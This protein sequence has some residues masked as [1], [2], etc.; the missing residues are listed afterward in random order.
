[1]TLA[2]AILALKA[3][4]RAATPGPLE[5]YVGEI[6]Q[7]YWT[8]AARKSHIVVAPKDSR[9]EGIALCGCPD[10]ESVEAAKQSGA[11]AVWFAAMDA[12][13]GAALLDVAEAAIKGCPLM[14]CGGSHY[15]SDKFP[16]PVGHALVALARAVGAERGIA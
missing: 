5:V 9:L 11:D 6:P 2:E 13:V 12:T 10:I 4:A 3:K 14:C 16:C 15:T 7:S 8:E 1:M